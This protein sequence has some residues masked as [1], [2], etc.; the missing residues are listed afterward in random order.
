MRYITILVFILCM[1]PLAADLDMNDMKMMVQKIKEP[2]ASNL[3]GAANISLT[4]P[5]VVVKNKKIT[6]DMIDPK[7]EPK[8]N[9]ILIIEQSSNSANL[10]LRATIN[11]EANVNGKW[12]HAGEGIGG[13]R[14]LYI[15][16][17]KIKVQKYNGEEKLSVNKENKIIEIRQE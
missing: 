14:I 16:N 11:D 8:L 7:K 9:P 5:F 6:K 13:Y 2:R 15:G 4:S 12:L 10:E 1:V 3:K 17:G